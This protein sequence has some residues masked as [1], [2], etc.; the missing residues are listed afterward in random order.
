[1]G[2][3]HYRFGLLLATGVGGKNTA[4][5]VRPFVWADVAEQFATTIRVFAPELILDAALSRRSGADGVSLQARGAGEDR[6]ANDLRDSAAARRAAA[7]RRSEAEAAEL[8]DENR[9]R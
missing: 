2:C 6:A 3:L 8:G 4:F 5:L 1:M 9:D 7:V